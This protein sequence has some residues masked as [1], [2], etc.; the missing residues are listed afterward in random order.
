MRQKLL[1]CFAL[2]ALPGTAL[3]A[4]DAALPQ[5]DLAQLIERLTSRE[6]A[7]WQVSKSSDGTL[8]ID[9]AG[10]FQHVALAKAGEHGLALGCVASLGQAKGFFA[11][12]IASSKAHAGAAG[13]D[14]ALDAIARRHGMAPAEYLFHSQ[15]IEHWKAGG[16][17][18]GATISIVKNDDP[19]E[20]FNSTA[21][22]F[23]PAPGNDGNANLGAQRLALFEAAAAVW[24]AFLDSE[25]EIQVGAEFNA[26]SPCSS[27]G[28]VLGSAGAAS[29][30]QTSSASSGVEF[31]STVYPVALFNKQR[32][33]DVDSGVDINTTFNSDVDTGCLGAGSRFYYG[34]DNATPSNTVNLFVVLL[35]ELGHGLGFASYADQDGSRPGNLPDIWARYQLD[36]S[37]GKTWD[38]MNDAERAAS[39]INAGNLFWIGSN[40][41]G[42]S[43]FL[44]SGRE[45]DQ[46]WVQLYAPAPYE[47]GSSV[48]HFATEVTPSVLMEPAI[49]AGLTLDLDLT[50]QLMRDIGW[51]RDSNLDSVADTISDVLPASGT[52]S[53]GQNVTIRW[54]RTSGFDRNVTIELSTDNGATFPTV[55][56]ENVANTG[57]RSWTVPDIATSQARLR[58]R[59][60]DFVAPAGTSANSFSI[61]GNTAP[62]F[63]PAAALSRQRGSAAGAAVS[64]GSVSDAETAAGELAVSQVA[65]GSASGVSASAISNSAGAV[66][67][68]VS[69]SCSAT[70]GTLR[71]QVSDGEDTGSGE[72]Q[73]NLSN[74]TPPALGYPDVSVDGG[75]GRSVAPNLGP[76]DNGSITTYQIVNVGT[77]SG[78]RSIDSSGVITL[79][80]A[81]PVGQHTLTIR[82][83]D[84]CNAST[85]VSF[86]LSVD[87][88]A[89]SFVPT[90]AVSR[91]QGSP[92]GPALVVGEVSDAQ[93]PAGNLSVIAITGGSAS[94]LEVGAPGNLD[95]TIRATL[96]ASC[97]ATAGTQRF[98]VSDGELASSGELQVDIIANAAPELGDYPDPFVI[99]AGASAAIQ[100]SAPAS[101]NGSIA[102]TSV[103][104]SGFGG[105]LALD[106]V[107]GQVTVQAAGPVG[108]FP[109]EVRLRD[110]C[111]AETLRSFLLRVS[112]ERIFANGFEAR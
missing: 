9:A 72:L 20:G 59:E 7:P 54:S 52:F 51:F 90:S 81:A 68:Q 92:A 38:Q 110:N 25:V 61:G 58:V 98:Q 60:H 50:R 39:A 19:G 99:E 48:S 57:S 36:A 12:D 78:S 73:V 80:S 45:P 56:A 35:H 29:L 107:S 79:G 27:S 24:A 34:L 8:G 84:N 104:A 102:E 94:G 31:T 88:T 2:L 109:V 3:A 43:D 47:A 63:T 108:D 86:S 62:T 40:V 49:T 55:I 93:T 41:K 65:G 44:S 74:N 53:P 4:S 33:I 106:P 26:L 30:F 13:G 22:Q 15:L 37:T 89:P 18:A 105:S 16:A 100:P 42:A 6:V 70:P 28:G 95:G 91:Q 17:K 66:S 10:G 46:G 5:P 32:G 83:I 21:A 96:A 85:D 71:F 11:R 64:V 103:A 112:A 77:Y 67:A 82:A 97:S 76:S 23:L 1:L 111:G 75:S 87:N 101:D 14:P 69:A